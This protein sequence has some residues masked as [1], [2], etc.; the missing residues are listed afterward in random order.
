MIS[1]NE[2]PDFKLQPKGPVSAAFIDHNMPTFRA[3]AQFVTALPYGRNK[4]KN[5]L[6]T[7]FTDNSGTCSTKHALLKQLAVEHNDTSIQLMLGL[8]KMNAT[9][10]PAIAATLAQHGLT[11][12]P[13]AHNYLRYQGIIFDFTKPGF[14]KAIWAQDLIE[15][16]EITPSH[17]TDFKV[18]YQKNYLAQWLKTNQINLSI[19]EIWA[20]REQCIQDLSIPN[21][22]QL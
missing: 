4:N 19:D 10:T 1:R 14:D 11:Y 2:F 22:T 3:A 17:I 21:K 16:M 7:V 8:F 15:E 5:D 6:I 20:I 9:N 13:E 18:A 12:L